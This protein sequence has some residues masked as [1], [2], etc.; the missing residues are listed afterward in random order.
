MSFS[1]YLVGTYEKRFGV[2]TSIQ[3]INPTS[4]SLDVVAAFFDADE[5]FQKCLRNRLSKNQLW[6]IIVPNDLKDLEP[7]FGVVKI[8]S[9]KREEG[10]IKPGIVGYQRHIL[11]V[12]SASEIA[13]SE[14][15]LAAVPNRYAQSEYDRISV[16]CP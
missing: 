1:S 5:R 9:H 4:A 15:P 6:E 7:E 14:S 16:H 2:G 11:V 13:F 10:I 3:I 12:P 8:I